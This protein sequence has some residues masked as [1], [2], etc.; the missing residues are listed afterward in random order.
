M[1]YIITSQ[2][3]VRQ[4]LFCFSTLTKWH[5]FNADQFGTT[6]CGLNSIC[7]TSMIGHRKNRY[8]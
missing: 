8:Y 7:K 1:K 4:I 5:E 2:E 6:L 3:S